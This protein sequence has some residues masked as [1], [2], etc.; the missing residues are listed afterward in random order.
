MTLY[1]TPLFLSRRIEKLSFDFC[2]FYGFRTRLLTT[3]V[4]LNINNNGD[5]IRFG[6]IL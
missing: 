1:T 6:V 4:Y 2:T 5:Q 3:L